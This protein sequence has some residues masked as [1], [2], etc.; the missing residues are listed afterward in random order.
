MS[1][2]EL[3]TEKDDLY[4]H[5]L[6]LACLALAESPLRVRERLSQWVDHLTSVVHSLCY[7]PGYE[8]DKSPIHPD[9]LEPHILAAARLNGRVNGVQLLNL[10]LT[11]P[12]HD[13][14]WWTHLVLEVAA[15]PETSRA[16]LREA[17]AA[18]HPD[19]KALRALGHLRNT[20][21]SD[22]VVDYLL[23]VLANK[24]IVV[25]QSAADALL[26]LGHAAITTVSK[27]ALLQTFAR[28][29]NLASLAPIVR[30]LIGWPETASIPR[31]VKTMLEALESDTD[32][33]STA[34]DYPADRRISAAKVL[35]NWGEVAAIP[36]T[37][38][39]VV[40]KSLLAALED[41]ED[42][43]L[44]KHAAEA[45]GNL[46]GTVSMVEIKACLNRVI[47]EDPEPSVS[48]A[49]DNALRRL[50]GYNSDALDRLER[51]AGTS[52]SLDL[53]TKDDVGS[54]SVALTQAT[55]VQELLH[56]AEGLVSSAEHVSVVDLVAAFLKVCKPEVVDDLDSV[57]SSGLWL[58]KAPIVAVLVG[59][60][61]YVSEGPPD[62]W[63]ERIM[64][65]DPGE[66]QREGARSTLFALQKAPFS[67]RIFKGWDD[68]K[69]VHTWTVADVAT[70][71]LLPSPDPLTGLIGN[72]KE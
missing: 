44:R 50:G 8:S 24:N 39:P 11:N 36:E 5:R 19:R 9:Y 37:E 14:A 42:S 15:T 70:L 34:I 16:L 71:A 72:T 64:T 40:V 28:N 62:D 45:L 3:S 59:A 32:T 47:R 60:T 4:R 12:A 31:A 17:G 20:A 55:S 66:Q 41:V 35:S 25:S 48:D 21:V 2:P 30:V 43:D 51:P 22:E 54:F 6:G 53:P 27:I 38:L 61:G 10:A 57:N 23:Q 69:Q 65:H 26:K 52:E 18:A 13:S 67:L 7:V 58:Q 46:G 63:R 68:E 49:A 29:A 1:R 33:R 56:A